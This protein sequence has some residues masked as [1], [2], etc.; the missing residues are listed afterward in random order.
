VT[1]ATALLA[2]V[3]FVLAVILSPPRLRGAVLGIIAVI[4]VILFAAAGYVAVTAP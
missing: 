3:A 1:I 2:A 4:V